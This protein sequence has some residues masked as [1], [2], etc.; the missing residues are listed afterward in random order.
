M[1]V[2]ILK[3]IYVQENG[4][5][6]SKVIF[7]NIV[8]VRKSNLH[9]THVGLEACHVPLQEHGQSKGDRTG[10]TDARGK[11]GGDRVKQWDRVKQ[12]RR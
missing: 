10:E 5:I 6:Q 8:Y 3:Y 9:L 7:E 11:A 1:C 4:I 12:G 2:S